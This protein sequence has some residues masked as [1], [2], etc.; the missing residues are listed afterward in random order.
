MAGTWMCGGHLMS[1]GKHVLGIKVSSPNL[2]FSLKASFFLTSPP[3]SYHSSTV[4]LVWAGRPL[5][6]DADCALRELSPSWGPPPQTRKTLRNEMMKKA[7][8]G[9]KCFQGKWQIWGRDF[10]PTNVFSV[11]QQMPT[12]H[13]GTSHLLDTD[14]YFFFFS[15]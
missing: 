12:T 1:K 3:S 10:N 9:K 15:D 13:S 4:L 5:W 6:G 14:S 7:W 11:T 8:S 2:P